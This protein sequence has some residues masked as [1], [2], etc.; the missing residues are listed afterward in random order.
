MALPDAWQLSE[1]GLEKVDLGALE[2]FPCGLVFG[3][4]TSRAREDKPNPVAMNAVFFEFVGGF[5]LRF[6]IIKAV[7][8][9]HDDEIG[10]FRHVPSALFRVSRAIEQQEVIPFRFS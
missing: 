4:R 2:V 6:E 9:R 7:A 1:N 8:S 3:W 10:R 5:D